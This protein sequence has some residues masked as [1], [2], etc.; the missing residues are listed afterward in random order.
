MVLTLTVGDNSME[1]SE[2]SQGLWRMCGTRSSP[3]IRYWRLLIGGA[4]GI[5]LLSELVAT[6]SDFVGD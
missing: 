3:R 6:I 5:A 2:T 1:G 4:G